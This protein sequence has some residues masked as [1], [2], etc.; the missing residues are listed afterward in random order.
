[1]EEVKKAEPEKIVEAAADKGCEDTEDMAGC[2]E[3]GI[4]PHVITDGG[5][6]GYE[7]EIP[8]EKAEADAASTDPEEIKK[9]LHAGQTPGAYAPVIQDMRVETVRRK[10]A[11]EKPEKAVYMEAGKK[12]RKRQKQD[13]L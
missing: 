3:K 11:D 4:I 5:K 13:I 1:M 2:L 9:A 12:C 6:D 7:I 10:A 8:Y